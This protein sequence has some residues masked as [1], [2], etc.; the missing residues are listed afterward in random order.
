MGVT[1][2]P[3]CLITHCLCGRKPKEN[4]SQIQWGEGGGLHDLSSFGEYV[5]LHDLSSFGEYVC[6]VHYHCFFL[7]LVG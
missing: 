2:L 3:L 5:G 4:L 7:C 1:T 6:L